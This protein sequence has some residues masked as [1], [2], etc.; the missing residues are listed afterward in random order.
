MSDPVVFIPLSRGMVAVIDFEDFDRVGRVKWHAVKTSKSG[1][2]YAARSLCEG[3][4]KRMELLSRQIL[5]APKG[6]DVD[7][8]NGDRL[9]NRK[10]NLRLAT[11]GQNLAA[12]KGGEKKW[13]GLEKTSSFRGVAKYLTKW[14]SQIS[15][16]GHK[17]HLGVFLSEEAAAKAYDAAA[18]KHFGEFAR[19]NFPLNKTNPN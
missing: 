8:I 2:F 13:R 12:R 15:I 17:K 18:M 6:M 5:N 10:E 9:D 16:N 14:V 19:C 11:R 4:R 3:G 7:H 1:R